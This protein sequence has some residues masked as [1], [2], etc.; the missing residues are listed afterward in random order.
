MYANGEGVPEDD[1]EAVRWYRLAADQGHANA[2]TN[3]GNMYNNGEGVPEDDAEAVR[4]Y[5]LAADQGNRLAQFN[6][7]MLERNGWGRDVN[8][9]AACEWFEKSAKEDVPMAQELLGDCYRDGLHGE[10]NFEL[11]KKW[12]LLAVE[13]GLPTSYCKLGKIYIAGKIVKKNERKGIRLCEQAGDKNS[14]HDQM[15]L[16]S[17]FDHG[18]P[19]T[20][21]AMLGNIAQRFPGTKLEWD[22]PN[23]TIPNHPDANRHMHYAYRDGWQL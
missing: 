15:Y 22:A 17:N 12:Y 21:I 18:G 11:A 6:L 20:E 10:A 1:E 3:L 14:I 5:R 4:W 13:N 8:P 2:Q 19:L 9:S 23:M 16:A 7:G